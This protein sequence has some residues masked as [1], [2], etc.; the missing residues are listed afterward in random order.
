M[1]DKIIDTQ[2]DITKKSRFR[3]FYESNKISIFSFILIL[4]IS[5]GSFSYYLTIKEN[6][7]IQLSEN[8]IKAKI[9]LENGKEKEATDLLKSVVFSNDS[10]YSTLSF[11]IIINQKLITD[12][13]E[14][15]V[16]YDH[17]IE[18]N[19]F[20]EEIKN[21]LIYKKALFKSKFVDEFEL[22]SDLK[23]LLNNNSLWEP[24]ALILIGDYFVA[25][26]Q[27]IKAKEFYTQVLSIKNLENNLY[28]YASSQLILIT[29]E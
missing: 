3:K 8:Y 9:Y 2:Y 6:K 24:H 13:K 28:S 20:D 18:N 25:K 21:L 4:F 27:K 7:K 11:F 10:T 29:N 14:I 22:L 15:L 12:N 16:L 26:K 1:T 23:P 19:N 5:F 17:L